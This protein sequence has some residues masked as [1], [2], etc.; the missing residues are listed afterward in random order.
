MATELATA[1]ISIVAETSGIPASI[2]AAMGQAGAEADR[3]GRQAGQRF[4]TGFGATM[5]G[6][7]GAAGVTAGLAGVAG[8]MKAAISSGMTFESS[9]NTMKAVSG[10]TSQ[11]LAAVSARARELGTDNQLAATSSVDAAQAMLELSKGGMSVEQ[12]MTA[13]RGTLQLAAAAQISAAEAATIQSSALQSFG[14]DASYAGTAA[15]ILANAA[16]ASSAEI[17]D[18]AYAFQSTGTVANQFGVSMQDTAA[19]IALMANSG[20]KGSDA[21]TLMKSA[22]L[23]LTDQ[24]DQ[25]QTQIEK[26]GLTVYDANGQFVGMSSLFGQLNKASKSMTAEQ[27]QAATATLFGSDAM[28]LAGIAAQQGKEGFDKI[29]AAMGRQGAAADVAA[30]KMSGL[31]G[32]W[33]RLKNTVQ[34][35]GLAFYDVA[36]GPLTSMANWGSSAIGKIVETATAAGPKVKAAW[37][38]VS[39]AVKDSGVLDAWGDRLKDVFASL[40]ESIVN[41]LPT[42]GTVGELM[43]MASAIIAAV[44]I[45][46]FVSALETLSGVLEVGVVPIAQALNSVMSSMQPLVVA[47]LAAFMGF[48]LVAPAL[49]SVGASLT[50]LQ[51]R[52]AAASTRVTTFAS[53][54]RQTVQWMRT[55]N[56][57]LSTAAASMRLLGTAASTGAATGISRVGTAAKGVVGALGGPFGAALAAAGVAVALIMAKNQRSA[58]S[59]DDLQ[60]AI[61]ATKSAQT[62]LNVALYEGDGAG[63]IANDD[64]KAAAKSRVDAYLSELDAAS[65]R[66]GSFGDLFRAG[67]TVGDSSKNASIA[68]YAKA[69]GDAKKAI[70]DLGMS[71]DNL[72]EGVYGTQAAFDSMTGKLKAQGPAGAEA[73]RGL[74]QARLQYLQAQ[75]SAGRSVPGMTAMSDA[76]RV[77]GDNAAT[78]EEKTNA[79]KAAMD[80]LNPAR[81]KG[82][83]LANVGETARTAVDQAPT[84]G[85]VTVDRSGEL[86]TTTEAGAALNDQLKKLGDAYAA[87]A[88]EGEDAARKAQTVQKP[89]FEAL[90]RQTGM[91]VAKLKELANIDD[92]NLVVKLSGTNEAVQGIGQVA[93]A[94]RKSPDKKTIN[95]DATAIEPARAALEKFGITFKDVI[96]P[97]GKKTGRVDVTAN[98]EE[99]RQK[100]VAFANAV[101][102][103]PPGKKIDLSTPGSTD[104][105]SLLNSVGAGVRQIPGTKDIAVTSPEAPAVKALLDALNLT[106]RTDNGKTILVKQQGAEKTQTDLQRTKKAVD[107]IPNEK[108]VTIWQAT[109]EGVQIGSQ[110]RFGNRATRPNADGSIRQYVD[111]GIT[112]LEAFANGGARLPDQALIQKADPRGGL[113]QWAE[114]STK[115]EAFIPLA[116]SKRARSTSILATVAKMFGFQLFP[117]GTMPDSLSGLAGGVTGSLVSSLIKRTGID[118]LTGVQKFAD[119]GFTSARTAAEFRQLAE[120]GFDANGKSL[121][122]APY[123]W[124]GVLWGDCSGA[125]SAFARFAAGLDVFGG[126][127]STASMAAQLAQM[128]A[129]MGRGPAGTMRFGWYNGGPGGGHTAGTL[130][131]GTN[132]E[133]GGGNG[134]GA[135]GGNAAGADAPQFTDHAYFPVA[136]STPT[137]DNT[138]GDGSGD[139]SGGGDSTKTSTFGSGD[140]ISGRF[141][142]AIGAIVEGQLAD[143]FEVFGANDSPGWLKAISEYENEQRSGKSGDGSKSGSKLSKEEKQKLKDTLDAAKLD[144][145]QAY[146]TEV[147]KYEDQY[148]ANQISKADYEQKKLDAKQRREDADLQSQ[149]EYD[150]KIGKTTKTDGGAKADYEQKKLDRKQA[151]DAEVARIKAEY[152]G[153]KLSDAEKA[154]RDKRLGDLKIKHDNED[155]KAQQEYERIKLRGDRTVTK[156]PAAQR[157]ITDP[158]T[159]KPAKGTDLPLPKLFDQGGSFGPGL[160]LIEN[161]L[162]KPETGLPFSPDE[163]KRALE[164][165]ASRGR[166]GDDYSVHI[167]TM[168]TAD[169]RDM[170]A[171]LFRQQRAAVMR[172]RGQVRA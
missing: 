52:T 22:L 159:D 140:S 46:T 39:S 91:T 72:V 3:Q 153:R 149:R 93:E 111:G 7:L 47:A 32:A 65:K 128:G 74:A 5:K 2:R 40:G 48:K 158:G 71:Q 99:A 77:L 37:D 78:A 13:A 16:N 6:M 147:Q 130:P 57:Q 172:G 155:L 143:M 33:E 96:G 107:D 106:T 151:Y 76:L 51:A 138:G 125:M 101:A 63:S 79:L 28:R 8:A 80:A 69:A 160:N 90:A 44:G 154:A 119:G 70:E 18:V 81:S 56:P 14:K 167:G 17:T 88:A 11:Q 29:A 113:V 146:D 42:L 12:S 68:R 166:A 141:G 123:D 85:K 152:Q 162:G 163:L 53:G 60:K 100:L 136:S 137:V 139:G 114:P 19:T 98:T 25:A 21:G 103:L 121:Q 55:G 23:A 127:F 89:A 67:D 112:A 170:K 165:G 73:A 92:A 104:V 62:E 142:S 118:N 129:V 84:I 58:Q 157:K 9:L 135:I 27:Y 49:A 82:E 97:D 131:D 20:I 124:G 1:Y 30:A 94:F 64:V 83:A 122:G 35:A 168:V 86:D 150:Q 34:D 126:R 156:P 108:T 171:G 144:H 59:F 54:W 45:E 164:L 145:K 161:R 31:P 61:T 110:T 87:A 117:D 133:M 75:Q 26:L 109:K 36:K 115:G 38:Q 134:G 50:T 169:S 105:I 41:L 95:L 24:G 43:E 66:S 120:G 148:T 10:A 102:A 15:D 4:S 116:D 132:V